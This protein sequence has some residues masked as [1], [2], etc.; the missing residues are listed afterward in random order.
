MVVKINSSG[1]VPIVFS[2]N[3]Y[4]IFKQLCCPIQNTSLVN[5]GCCE[6]VYSFNVS[7]PVAAGC[8][9]S[10]YFPNRCDPLSFQTSAITI[11]PIKYAAEIL[12]GDG[13]ITVD[14]ELIVNGVVFQPLQYL[15]TLG[16]GSTGNT[17]PSPPPA[18]EQF[19]G[20]TSSCNGQHTIPEGT[21]IGAIPEGETMTIA[22]G[23]NHG[24]DL[25]MSGQI[26]IRPIGA[27]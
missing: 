15:V 4:K 27:P 3:K 16:S 18:C 11:G 2:D 6:C 1:R 26:V 9:G 8:G 5:E 17:N 23:D 10:T 19:S 21:V 25:F 7:A 24:I 20:G 22:G 12:A 14:D 13:G